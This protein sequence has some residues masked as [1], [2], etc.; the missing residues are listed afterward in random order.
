MN[1]VPRWITFAAARWAAP[2]LVAGLLA[3]AATLAS[4]ATLTIACGS[5]GS[6]LAL[7]KR[8]ADTWARQT[9]NTIKTFSP[10]NSGTEALALY[11]QLFA[12]K[13]ADIDVILID[14]VWPG[15]IKDHLLDLKPYSLGAEAEHFPAIVA[16]NT[17]NGK[18]L[19]MPFYTDTGVLYYRSDLLKKYGFKPPE[20]W[21]DL[22][23][24]ATRIQAAE[25]AAGKPDFQG[26]VFQAKAYEGLSCNALEW[27]AGWGGGTLVDAAGNITIN[28]PQAA[29][30]LNTAASW[31]GTI[32]PV[33]VLNYGEEDAR[34]VFQ[35]GQA[36]FM[37]SW[38]YAWAAAQAPDSGIKGKVGV[39]PLPRGVGDPATTRHAGTLGGWQLAVSR[40]S[41]NPE[42]AA[43]L[44]MHMTSAAVQKD[45]AIQGSF[46]PTR[47]ALYQ[48]P[49]VIA[50]NDFMAGL[51]EMLSTA[52][53]RP[54]GLAGVKYPAVSLAFWDAAHEV[55]TKKT[56]GEAAV[57]K[58]EGKLKLIRREQW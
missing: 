10:P 7:C 38:P 58:L 32:A 29:K 28:N 40:Y 8:H 27:V 17:V 33:G 50:A 24:A 52:V 1:P 20:T 11:R 41:R 54:S 16:N 9:G 22:T 18:L 30:A 48:D 44:V 42:A 14:I 46:N 6:D 37:R 35:N 13:S 51:V 5:S 56:T 19:G 43:S 34:G 47:P 26:F 53:A 55:L 57:R 2:A 4:A 21:D 12:A 49:E 36:L 23:A 39:M 15:I 31:I 25:R 45:R 3:G